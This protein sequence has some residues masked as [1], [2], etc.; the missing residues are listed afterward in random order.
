[1]LKTQKKIETLFT[2]CP[3]TSV[4]I[5][6]KKL[7]IPKSTVSDIKVKKLGIRVQTQKKVTKYV[8]DQERR[9]KTGLRKIYKKTLRKTFVID[10]ETYVV[11]EPEGQPERKY[12]ISKNHDELPFQ[13]KFKRIKKFRKKY[14]V[15][16]AVDEN[17]NV[18]K[19]YVTNKNL[20]TCHAKVCLEFLTK[21]K[22]EFIEEHK[23]LPNV[24]QAKGI[25]K[26]WALC[27]SDY[28]NLNMFVVPPQ[29]NARDTKDDSNKSNEKQINDVNRLR[30]RI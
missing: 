13:F 24:P 28:D 9:A 1:M 21:E 11:L 25:E 6:A 7:N 15:W 27:N 19:P 2:K 17:G 8:K 16:Q 23:N 3:T 20:A 29:E 14:L 26:F 12:V 10:D 4:R 22:L 30:R 5:V 18:L